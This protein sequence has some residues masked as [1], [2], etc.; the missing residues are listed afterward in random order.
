MYRIKAAVMRKSYYE[1][2]LVIDGYILMNSEGKKI[3]TNTYIKLFFKTKNT[4]NLLL[5][6]E[7]SEVAGDF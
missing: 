6:G 3:R 7:R 1:A 4:K 5:L 2:L